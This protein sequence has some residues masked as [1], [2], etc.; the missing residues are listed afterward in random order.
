VPSRARA[1]CP[2]GI[3]D[4]LAINGI[5]NTPLETAHRFQGRPSVFTS[6]LVQGL[7]TG[8]ADRNRDGYISARTP[9]RVR[10]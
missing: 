1:S 2:L 5:R 10:T 9:L 4:Q 6:A 7:A 8:E 3:G